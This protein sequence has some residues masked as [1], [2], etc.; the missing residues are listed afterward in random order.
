[1][2]RLTAFHL[3]NMFLKVFKIYEESNHKRFLILIGKIANQCLKCTGTEYKKER[4]GVVGGKHD[5]REGVH[6]PKQS[7]MIIGSLR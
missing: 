7:N 4:A 6:S 5:A 1:M 2:E 3:E